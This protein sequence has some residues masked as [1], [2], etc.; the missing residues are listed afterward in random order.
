[1]AIISS[2]VVNPSFSSIARLS[3]GDLIASFI[4]Y[5]SLIP[6]FLLHYVLIYVLIND[7]KELR[8]KYII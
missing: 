7:H 5:N 1:L 4:A 3:A 8:S 6:S 2:M